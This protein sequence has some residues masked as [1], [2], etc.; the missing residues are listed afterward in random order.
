MM[1]IN[2]QHIDEIAA[3][4][5][6]AANGTFAAAGK[7]IGR[8][9]TIIS[10]RIASLE[11]RLGVRLV[12]R[13]TRQVQLTDTGKRLAD[14][15]RVATDLIEEAQEEATENA[16]NLS[17]RLKLAFPATMGR[18][19]LAPKIPEFMVKYPNLELDISYSDNYVDLIEGG[20]DAAI[21][22][23]HLTDSRLVARK[24]ISHKRILVASPNYLQQH[25][26]PLEPDQLLE[27]NCIGNPSLHSYP[28]WRLSD[29]QQLAM[30]RTN[31]TLVT[32]DSIAMLE[33]AKAG[34][35]ILGAGEWLVAQDIHSGSLVQLMPQWHFDSDGGIYLVRA[36]RHYI[37]ART[38]AFGEWISQLFQAAPWK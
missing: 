1:K 7:A 28:I 35:G 22:I 36:S 19:W 4:L 9:P 27:H 2:S 34:I 6:I 23:G 8:H 26:T 12:E 38:G 16:N 31:G 37:S 18:L 30:V 33:A 14:K 10:K 11:T 24:L 5:A 20:F 15:Y 29:G 21:R 17:G 32:N 3:L 25:G 13:T